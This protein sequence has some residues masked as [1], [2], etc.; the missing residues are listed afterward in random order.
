MSANGWDC[1]PVFLV[2]WQWGVQHWSLQA[3]VWS[4]V[5]VSRWIPMGEHK[6]INISWA[7]EVSDGPVSWTQCSHPGGP[8]LIPGQATKCPQAVQH[9]QRIKVKKGKGNKY[10]KLKTN[11]KNKK[12]QQQQCT[13]ITQTYKSN[14][15]QMI[16]QNQRNTNKETDTEQRK[17]KISKERS[18]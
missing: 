13:H 6:P 15:R 17:Q 3:V 18:K 7:Q 1:V 8:R 4:Q 9:G 12:K 14:T 10:R 16:K 5:L 2:I 11:S